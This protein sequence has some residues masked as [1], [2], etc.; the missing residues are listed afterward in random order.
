MFFFQQTIFQSDL[1][2]DLI[3]IIYNNIKTILCFL[4]PQV[5][6]FPFI[7]EPGSI[8]SSVS[9]P[10]GGDKGGQHLMRTPLERHLPSM[11]FIIWFC[12]QHQKQ[13]FMYQQ[14]GNFSCFSWLEAAVWKQH[15]HAGVQ[16]CKEHC[17]EQHLQ[18]QNIFLLLH[19][20]WPWSFTSFARN[21]VQLCRAA[22]SYSFVRPHQECSL[23]CKVSSL[24]L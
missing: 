15:N 21:F 6:F 18:H 2:I 23:Q 13:P 12:S 16:V 10:L 22:G 24:C 14:I 5:L 19:L 1:F 8:G 3:H 17:E 7:L 9:V 20:F 4:V 11:A